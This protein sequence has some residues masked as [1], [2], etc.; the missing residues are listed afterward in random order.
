MQKDMLKKLCVGKKETD[1]LE[2]EVKRL[3]QQ[4]AEVCSAQETCFIDWHATKDTAVAKKVSEYK[5]LAQA[6]KLEKLKI[7]TIKHYSLLMLR[8]LT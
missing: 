3:I 4:L 6:Q 7:F 5:V 1:M 2:A 8:L